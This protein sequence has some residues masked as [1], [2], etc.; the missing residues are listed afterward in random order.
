MNILRKI[1]NA[2]LLNVKFGILLMVLVA[3]Y[4]A[5]GSGVPAVRE[6]VEKNE[7]EFF[8]WWPFL[9]LLGLLVSNLVLVTFNRIPFT[10]PRYGVWCVH[11]GIITLIW[12]MSY[13]YTR[14]VEGLTLIPVG[15]TVGQF[16]DS[17]TR[18]LYAQAGGKRAVPIPLENLPRFEEYGAE[19]NNARRLDRPD[20]VGI[21]PEF[22]S[23]DRATGTL[24]SMP[25]GQALG[26][27]QPASL[28][29]VGYW[30][31]AEIEHSFT[32]DPAS[33]E[34]G[35]VLSRVDPKDG[36]TESLFI[37]PGDAPV[38][39]GGAT[40]EFRDLPDAA[41]L[42][43][44]KAAAGRL[45]TIDAVIDGGAPIPLSVEPGGTYN[46]GPYKLTIGQIDPSFPMFGTGEIVQTLTL[47]VEGPTGTFKRMLLNGRPLQTDFKL[48][49][50]GAGPMGKRQKTPLDTHLVLNYA[51]NDPLGLMPKTAPERHLFFT[52][53]EGKTVTHVRTSLDGPVRVEALANG[54]G[55]VALAPSADSAGPSGHAD[56][57]STLLVRLRDHVRRV[58]SVRIT[59]M[60]KR[61]KEIGQ[62]VTQQGSKQVVKIRVKV[63]DWWGDVL[64]PFT[65]FPDQFAW[66][67]GEIKI[68]GAA[69]PL[70]LQ[71]GNFRRPLPAAL[72]LDR[73]EL[74][75]Y[76]GGLPKAGS[77]MRDFKSHLT[78][79]DRFTGKG[80]PAVA[81]LN[82]PVYFGSGSW[83]FYQ[84]QWDPEGQR[85]TILGVGNRPGM[86]VMVTGCVLILAGLLYAFYAKPYVIRAMKQRALRKAG[87]AAGQAGS[88]G[89]T[90]GK[91]G[92][93]SKIK[94][95]QEA[96]LAT[97]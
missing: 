58:D 39:V 77:L 41:A 30:P 22:S 38:P 25:L 10:P 96:D 92:R 45:N 57:P 42:D 51:L 82:S 73:F 21:A 61:D 80:T 1:F 18:A 49:E 62:G 4:V 27:D 34:R 47:T 72:K 83:L 40:A 74:V 53:G 88:T 3:A 84:A 75:P 94:E 12:G 87:L 95:P 43:A 2:T 14:K 91:K 36:A 28:Q 5:I 17:Q 70:T 78:V 8:A 76:P 64:V 66:H 69:D 55:D 32:T 46:A 63:G 33:T 79:F 9:L 90:G 54:M 23:L 52:A 35:V 97:A 44:I 29:I 65:Q 89:G 56:E 85:W 7:L 71:L 24:T 50:P 68:P 67:D 59:P 6:L 31:Y 37:S 20:L 48:G 11:A 93:G 81:Q 16:Y 19:F 86:G 15:Q 13:Y 26:V 60:A